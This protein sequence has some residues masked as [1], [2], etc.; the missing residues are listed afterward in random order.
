ML[1]GTALAA[2]EPGEGDAESPMPRVIGVEPEQADDGAR[3]LREGRIVTIE[4]PDTIADGLRTRFLG[5][6]TFAVIQRHVDSIVT[7]SEESIIE[8]LRWLWL[9]MKL[10]VEPSSAVPLAAL[11]SGALPAKGERVG[12]I[13]S[14]GNIDPDSIGEL[15][16]S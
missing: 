12:V 14:G 8:A 4:T 5:E 1:S 11:L 16:R 15:L 3:S 13:L 6:H 9:H 10:L 7:V 2:L